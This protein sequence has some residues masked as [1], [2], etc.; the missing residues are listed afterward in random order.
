L[1]LFYGGFDIGGFGIGHALN[2]NRFSA[3]DI[4]PA[5]FDFSGHKISPLIIG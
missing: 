3:P 4:K 5:D 1:D 2:G